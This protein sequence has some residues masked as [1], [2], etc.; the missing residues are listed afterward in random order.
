MRILIIIAALLLP[1]GVLC[2]VEQLV[3]LENGE[4]IRA[5]YNGQDDENLTITPLPIR[6]N[7]P[8]TLNKSVVIRTQTLGVRFLNDEYNDFLSQGVRKLEF[9][10]LCHTSD[11]GMHVS[12]RELNDSIVILFKIKNGNESKTYVHHDVKA[13]DILR[14][15]LFSGDTINLPCQDTYILRGYVLYNFGILPLTRDDIY[16][17]INSPVEKVYLNDERCR[18]NDGYSI[19]RILL[20]LMESNQPSIEEHQPR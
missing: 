15:I 9:Q 3:Y 6:K 16:K 12:G 20:A 8:Q 17:L 2:Q 5:E 10:K 4:Y 13:G 14:L 19:M 1:A 7:E 18:M 11:W